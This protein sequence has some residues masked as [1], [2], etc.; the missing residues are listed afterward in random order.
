[1]AQSDVSTREKYTQGMA[2]LAAAD[3]GICSPPL[4]PHRFVDATKQPR[5]KN[6]WQNED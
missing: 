3:D 2:G 4:V 5:K 6:G 1:M